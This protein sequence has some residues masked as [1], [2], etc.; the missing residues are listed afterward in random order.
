M[1]GLRLF[2]KI[3]NAYKI[4]AEF[5]LASKDLPELYIGYLLCARPE[6]LSGGP[7]C[8]AASAYRRTKTPAK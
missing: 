4:I 6:N 7:A 8:A 2:S 1:Q 3:R 5:I